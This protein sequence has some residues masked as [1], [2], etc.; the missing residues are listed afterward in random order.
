MASSVD[1][2][3]NIISCS[4]LEPLSKLE[5]RLSSR[6]ETRLDDLLPFFFAGTHDIAIIS[7]LNVLHG[8]SIILIMGHSPTTYRSE[9]YAN[10][11]LVPLHDL[12]LP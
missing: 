2:V 12:C 3:G 1:Y 9:D 7:M 4:C 11:Q 5:F 8:F 6:L 10:F